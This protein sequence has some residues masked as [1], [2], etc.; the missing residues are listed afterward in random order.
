VPILSFSFL[1]PT[2]IRREGTPTQLPS[3]A[4]G[5]FAYL[6]VRRTPV[7]REQVIELLWPE[8]PPAAGRKNLRNTLWV[9]R[10]TLGNAVVTAHA[11]AV[12]LSEDVWVDLHVF[13]QDHTL[14]LYRGSLLDGLVVSDAPEF[15]HWLALQREDWQARYQLFL[16]AGIEARRMAGDWT[17]AVTLAYQGLR[18]APFDEPLHRTVMEGLA[19]LG[20]PVAALRH[21]DDWHATLAKTRGMSPG[22]DTYALRDAIGAG[23]LP[24]AALREPPATGPSTQQGKFAL[25]PAEAS[26]YL[27][28]AQ[29][30]ALP[31]IRHASPYAP[32][33]PSPLYSLGRGWALALSGDRDAAEMAFEQ[34]LA[35][36]TAQGEPR[37]ATE[38]CFELAALALSWGQVDQAD[39]WTKRGLENLRTQHQTRTPSLHRTG[40]CLAGLVLALEPASPQPSEAHDANK[41]LVLR[42]AQQQFPLLLAGARIEL[43]RWLAE[44][45]ELDETMRSLVQQAIARPQVL[46]AKL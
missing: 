8:R 31:A 14:D 28:L 21:F 25:W 12:A 38:A 16:S 36:F 7:P 1:G 39:A 27:C 30:S 33:D 20:Q 29:T 10:R 46:L 5:L 6:A 44:R 37:C 40:S 45:G 26:G 34:A 2:E 42:F 18:F 24:E 32:E 4:I 19:R 23:S 35:S 15:E 13:A 22:R 3:K 11:D 43:T 9:V 41:E 17:A